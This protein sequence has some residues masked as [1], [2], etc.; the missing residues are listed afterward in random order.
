MANETLA[1]LLKWLRTQVHPG[2][3]IQEEF[4]GS[5]KPNGIGK[6]G[7]Y[8]SQ[9]EKGKRA[10]S[11]EVCCDVAEIMA[12]HYA[13]YEELDID[14]AR[15]ALKH[16]L[17]IARERMREPAL[18]SALEDSIRGELKQKAGGVIQPNGELLRT[19]LVDRIRTD[20]A[21]ESAIERMASVAGVGLNEMHKILAREMPLTR[22]GIERLAKANNQPPAEY[23]V[24]GGF[25]P[26]ADPGK[27]ATL[28]A[29][30]GDM[31]VEQLDALA[32]VAAV[33]LKKKR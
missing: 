24:L 6:T 26:H 21:A 18:V 28:L 14:A 25:F 13:E 12:K 5:E 11:D 23:L 4:Y 22:A 7:S 33:M 30:C 19:E 1:D 29:T 9:L 32:G 10:P 17:R 16:R 8:G 20:A 15:E 3:P 2:T 31:T 27:F